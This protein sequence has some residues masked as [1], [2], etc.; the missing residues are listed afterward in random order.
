MAV[1]TQMPKNAK[2][3][4]QTAGW[5]Q[6]PLWR[7]LLATPLSTLGVLAVGGLL[8]AGLTGAPPAFAEAPWWHL[9]SSSTPTNLPP[10]GEGRIVVTASNLGDAAVSGAT[11]PVAITDKLPP[12]LTATGIS[13]IAGVRGF[14]GSLECSLPS[15]TCSF[16]GSELLP[17]Y[18]QL[19]VVITVK[20]AAGASS[21]EQNEAT[22]AGG[23]VPGALARQSIM[24]NGAPAS[25]GV[26]RYEVSPENE[27]G[28]PDTQAGSHPYQLTTTLG[29]NQILESDHFCKECGRPMPA[30]LPRDLRFDLPPGLIG[31]PSAVPQCTDLEFAALGPEAVN[32]C[33]ANTAI[34][35]ASA[36]INVPN[37]GLA[38]IPVPVF[39][40]VPAAG[41][42]ARF[43]F[44]AEGVPVVLDTSVRTGGDYGVVV[45]ATNLSQSA[46]LLA[47]QVTFW[48]VPGDPRHDHSR[49]WYCIGAGVY[50]TEG[51]PCNPLGQQRPAPFLTLPTSCTG[52]LESTVAGDSWPARP[53]E[54]ESLKLQGKYAF[55]VSA[56]KP[57]GLDGCNRLAFNP[58]V[59]VTPDGLAASTPTGLTVRV[60]VPQDTTLTAT[61]LAESDVKD[62]TVT[63]PEG[64]QV[65]AAAADGLLACSNQQIGFRGVNPQTQIDEFSP[66]PAACPEASKVGTVE[67]IKTPL[68]PN[69][70]KGSVYVAAQNANPFGSLLALYLVAEDPVSKVLVKLAGKV[71]PDERTGQLVSTFEHTPQLPFEDL[72]LHFFGGPR[73]PLSTPAY[74]GSYTTTASLA[75]WSGNTPVQPQSTFEVK[76]GP[77]G[78]P[79]ANPLPFSPSLTGGS[80][81]IQ[82]GTFAPFTTTMSREDGNQ[83]LYGVQLHMPQGLLGMLSSVTPCPEPQASEGT[84]G[85]KS[86][87]G[88]TVVSVGLGSDPYTVSGGQVFITRAYKGAPYGLSIAEPAKAGPFDLGGGP[89]DCVVV[90]AK[91]D[92]DR[93]TSALTVTSDP[94]PQILDGIPLQVKHVNVTADRRAFIFNPTNCSPLAITAILSSAQG[95]SSLASVPFQVANCATLPFK[96]RFTV[97]TLAH[98][99]KAGGAYLHVKVTSGSGQANIGKVKVDLPMQLPSRL[100][101]LQK[102]C[103]SGTFNA[104]PASCPTGSVV[105]EAT[106]VTPVLNNALKGPAYLVSH[107]GAAFPDL[108]MVLQGEGITLDLVGQTD[109]KRGITSSTF[110]SVPDAPISTFDLVLP[111]GPHSAL[112]AHG[113]LCSTTLKMPT[114]LTGQNGAVI[115]QTTRIAVSGC[116]KHK[117]PKKKVTKAIKKHTQ[118]R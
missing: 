33:P 116:P 31:N 58:S 88:H 35:A 66:E 103:L 42:P 50:A 24:V 38:T 83:N 71:A 23:E 55:P 60:H 37:V 4:G 102:A 27:G 25:F 74:C 62:T 5:P 12:G 68:L 97:L 70:L 80:T 10:G 44:E 41:E 26:E 82:A 111:Q 91:I 105:G 77:N 56:G 113:N 29:L 54:G 17:P 6:S 78:S 65:S 16:A 100:T 40:L 46:G 59:S 49:G 90:R 89:C 61:G 115:K 76:S 22:V 30:A 1:E 104:N 15:L 84:C 32:L 53:F 101:T 28:T 2:A 94:L 11:V 21:G 112:A 13:G 7:R 57:L 73:A 63:L 8:L 19:E 99:S 72:K 117:K 98:T 106:A 9:A 48:G 109:I 93:N 108:V 43:G 92:V 67:E 39:N 20:I 86:L 3:G 79:C 81:N 87:I 52:P 110:Q 51:Q 85:A 18:E 75:P 14:R 114:A 36:T 96:P 47:S 69:P 107:G 64:V 45:S 118:K 95:A 34:G